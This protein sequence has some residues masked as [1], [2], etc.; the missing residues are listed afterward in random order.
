[1]KI[2]IL[3]I[4]L[5]LLL[6]PA[7]SND[8]E[9]V[10]PDDNGTETGTD[11]T[12]DEDPYLDISD[13]L[14]Y[15][16]S[17]KDAALIVVRTNRNWKAVCD[18]DWVS[19]TTADGDSTTG[20]II[21]VSKNLKFE[22]SATVTVTADNLSKKIK[23]NQKGVSKIEFEI[24]GVK[25]T[26]L[27]VYADTTFYLDGAT[28]IASRNVYLDSY[29]ISETEI[30]NEQWM[31]ITGSLPYDSE[32]SFP[33]QPVVV[34]WNNITENFI[35]ALNSLSEYN[36][37]LPTE[38]EWEVA[39]RGG[40]KTQY[41]SYAGSMYI[42]SVA[43]YFNNSGGRKHNVA[44]KKPNELGLYDMSGNVSEWCS[45]WYAEWTDDNPPPSDSENPTGPESGTEKVLRGGDFIAEQ[46]MYDI[47]SCTVYS[48]N[49]LPPDIDTEGFLYNGYYHYPGFRLVIGK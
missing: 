47:N 18:S 48:R 4:Y 36:F 23:I 35:P 8:E 24:N 13:S 40:L 7:C 44:Q 16:S 28:Y 5:L 10:A 9:P 26:F 14:L 3:I 29:F 39:A 20:F 46:F 1:M 32:N 15:F 12:Q 31:S 43:W 41:F 30:T 11:D 22:R 17:D 2:K 38:N 49:H 45:D 34:N 42:D 27:P 19:F 6:S 37:R 33:D 21:G 25:F